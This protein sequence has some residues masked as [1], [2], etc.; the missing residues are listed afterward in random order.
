MVQ[1]LLVIGR[2]LNP[3]YVLFAPSLVFKLPPGIW[4]LV[5]P[6]LLT[7]PKLGFFFDLYFSTIR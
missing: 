3:F 4:R 6:F 2:L 5:T 7:S 1:S